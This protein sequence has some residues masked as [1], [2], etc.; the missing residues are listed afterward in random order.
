MICQKT[1]ILISTLPFLICMRNLYMYKDINKTWGSIINRLQTRLT[2]ST[3]F[4]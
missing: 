2:I 4:I 1:F 3:S